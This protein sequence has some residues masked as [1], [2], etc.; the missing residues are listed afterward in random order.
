MNVSKKN[1]KGAV[2]KTGSKR[3]SAKRVEEDVHDYFHDD[4]DD[5]DEIDGEEEDE[6][7]DKG[8]TLDELPYPDELASCSPA[9]RE[10]AQGVSEEMGA[11]LEDRV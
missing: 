7:E 10:I 11:Y 1:C 5:E 4:G 9:M 2:G 8:P 3:A 6:V